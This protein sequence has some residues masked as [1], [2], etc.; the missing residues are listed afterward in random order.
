MAALKLPAIVE[1]FCLPWGVDLF[2][3]GDIEAVRRICTDVASS[4]VCDYLVLDLSETAIFGAE[5][6]GSLLRVRRQLA[7]EGCILTISHANPL[8]T[9]ILVITNLD[10][11]LRPPDNVSLPSE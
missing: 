9:E 6:L 3:S 2:H 1:E 11:L 4:T 8:C 7:D 5:F 10:E